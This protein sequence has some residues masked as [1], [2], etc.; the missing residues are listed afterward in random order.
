MRRAAPPSASPYSATLAWA[1]CAAASLGA[2]GCQPKPARSGHALAEPGNSAAQNRRTARATRYPAQPTAAPPVALPEGA[3]HAVALQRY[4]V[5][6]QFG[7]TPSMD[8]FAIAIDPQAGWNA[9]DQYLPNGPF[10]VRHWAS[11]KV[12]LKGR[13]A[14]WH[15]GAVDAASGDRGAWF[16][17]STLNTPGLYYVYDPQSNL[18]SHPFEVGRNVYVRVLS[19]A[20]RAFYFNRANSAKTPPYACVEEQCWS[21]EASHTGQRQDGQARS[22]SEPENASTS[23]ELTGGWWDGGTTA[24]SVTANYE[25]VHGLLSAFRERPGSFNDN[26]EIPESGN[27]LPDILDELKIQLDWLRKMQASDL[28]GGALLKVGSVEHDDEVPDKSR[29][30]RLYTETPCSSATIAIA[31]MFAHASLVMGRFAPLVGY[32]QR[33]ATRAE[34]ALLNYRTSPKSDACDPGRFQ[35]DNADWPLATQEQAAVTASVYLWALHKTAEHKEFVADHYQETIPFLSDLWSV[36]SPSQGDALLFYASHQ[37]ADADV[38]RAIL[39][40][41]R[42][43]SERLDLYRFRPSFDLYRAFIRPEAYTWGSNGFR[44]GYA[45]TNQD[46]LQHKL[47]DNPA[48]GSSLRERAAGLLHSLHGVNAMQLVFVTNMYN[49]GAEASADEMYHAWFRDGSATWDN[50]RSSTLG[51]APGFVTAGPNP[52]YCR[53]QTNDQACT[54]SPVADQPPAKAYVDSNTG[55]EPDN[56]FDKSW[57]MTEP[58]LATQA[59]YI[60]L[61]SKF[62]YN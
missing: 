6:D 20:L 48:T 41:K 35:G 17:F 54:R 46:L 3:G 24:K 12:A 11:G 49:Y 60:R 38:R 13:L 26:L 5:V 16:N 57:Q 22:L 47:L 50:A 23:R 4:I 14:P 62:V 7:Y 56:P 36:H 44:M 18:R 31:S 32:S 33:L 59:A 52:D 21:L 1:F 55:W 15:E 43:Q 53:N 42:Q 10:E 34:R 19:A 29:V 39:A 37:D 2:T 40:R 8:K 27:G 25:A 61:L 9:A 58:N 51:P 45:N 30:P 28:D